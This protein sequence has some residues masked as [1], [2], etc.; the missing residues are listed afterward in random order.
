MRLLFMWIAFLLWAERGSSAMLTNYLS[1]VWQ[2]D[3][4]AINV[5]DTV[6]WVNQAATNYLESYGGE[7]Q[8]PPMSKGDAFS[9][10]FTNAGFYVY[11]TELGPGPRAGTVDVAPWTSAPRAVTLNTPVEGAVLSQAAFPGNL[12]EASATNQQDIVELQYFANSSLI[13]T[14]TNAPYALQWVSPQ[15]GS[16]TLLA[17]A[18]DRQGGFSWSQPVRVTVSAEFY[19]YGFQLMPTGQLLGFYTGYATR[20]ASFVASA[21]NLEF[22]NYTLLAFIG[23]PGV[24]VDER[25]PGGVPYRFYGVVR[26]GPGV[27]VMGPGSAGKSAY[28]NR[29]ASPP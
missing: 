20:P 14:T 29:A 1:N 3:R 8:S 5:G 13:G 4:M 25:P 15:P 22:T 26:S 11:R 10:T 28:E 21:D 9:F 19:L 18:I 16:Y 27:A 17:E 24:F 7:W 6:V 2:E 12:L 23:R